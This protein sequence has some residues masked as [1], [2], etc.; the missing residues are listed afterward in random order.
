MQRVVTVI[1]AG[2][3]A[4][5]VVARYICVWTRRANSLH[6]SCWA[7]DASEQTIERAQM[8]EIPDRPRGRVQPIYS[9]PRCAA[10]A[11]AWAR[12]STTNLLK[13]WMRW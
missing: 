7:A 13:I 10:T 2:V 1:R 6:A 4:L 9:S 5:T 12:V 8:N 3:C 11:T